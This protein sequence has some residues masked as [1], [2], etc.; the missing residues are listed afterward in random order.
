[1][2]IIRNI[3]LTILVLMIQS[4]FGHQISV[5]NIK[6]DLVL[7]LLIY[8]S[9]S[10]GQIEGAL[11]GFLTGFLQDVYSPSYFGMNTLA[12]SIAGFAVGHGRGVVTES[13][14]IQTLIVFSAVFLHD[15]VYFACCSGRDLS[16]FFFLLFR[17]GLGTA[18]YTTL[19]G[20]CLSVIL[21]FSTRGGL[22]FNAK[23][24]FSE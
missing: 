3:L 24:L 6:P 22:H 4:S 19:L 10:G 5:L 12:K 16:S 21:S 15:M 2:R 23:R 8:I 14:L 11:F 1:M 9:L 20:I 17:Y 13:F 7:L 18:F